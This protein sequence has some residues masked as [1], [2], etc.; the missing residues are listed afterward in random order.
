V[1]LP[2][3]AGLLITVAMTTVAVAIR[4][5]VTPWLVTTRA[6][7]RETAVIGALYSVW[8]LAGTLSVMK[9]DKALDR[10]RS[11]W[12]LERTLH[13]PSEVAVQRLVLPHP[14]LV[15]AANVF[16]AWAHATGLLVFLV[17]LF[18]RH[19]ERYPHTRNVIALV[20]GTCLAIQLVPVAPPRM[21]DSLGFV[22]TALV[23]GQSVYTA[24][25][26]GLADQLSAMPSV[27]VA[28]AVLIAIVVVR[29]GSGR[30][31][32][33]VVVHPVV[34]IVAV[35]ATANHFW[36]DGIVAVAL[37]G[38][39]Y[40]VLAAADALVAR[41]RRRRVGSRPVTGETGVAEEWVALDDALEAPAADVQS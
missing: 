13:L 8:Q 22:D 28:W 11:I 38:V 3:E 21:L 39:A 26:R 4:R 36:L 29:A 15:Q 18:F 24:L 27:H 7:A 32:W 5:P 33:W 30:W 25:G 40:L 20:T 35:V 6:V 31:R 41:I 16:Y 14:T 17:W 1:W 12:D 37:I 9:V 23:Y 2:W 10:G 19:R 34:T